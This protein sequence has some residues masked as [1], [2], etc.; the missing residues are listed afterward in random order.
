MFTVPELT[1]DYSALE[2]WVDETTMRLHHDKHH[3]TY[4]KNVND[5]LVGHEELLN[6][7]INALIQNLHKVP[8]DVRT[9]VKN[10][11][12]GHANHTL[13]WTM[14]APGAEKT[15]KGTIGEKLG[16]AFG[17]FETFKAEFTKA[18]LGVFGSGWAWVITD[19]DSL[20]IVTTPNQDTP[21]MEGKHP[22]LGIDVWE[23]AYYLKYQNK[24]PEYVEAWFN[25]INWEEVERR[26]IDA[27]K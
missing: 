6:M 11:G 18:A 12:G 23:H 8:E 17:E 16:N 5:A 1:Y 24:R 27:S 15:P 3:A 19:G 10:N 14:M 4:V 26:L 25:V 7:D 20:K 13:F 21:V 22:I 9:K 2:P